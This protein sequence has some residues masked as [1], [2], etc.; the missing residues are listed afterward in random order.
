MPGPWDEVDDLTLDRY[1]PRGTTPL[2]DAL[3]ALI[4][5]VDRRL[6]ESGGSR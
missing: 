6:E 1:R 2:L 5:S 3:G 4:E